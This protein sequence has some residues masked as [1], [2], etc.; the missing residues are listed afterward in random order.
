MMF[1]KIAFILFLSLIS[2]SALV[3]QEV[4]LGTLLKEMVAREQLAMFP[5]RDYTTEQFSSYDR[6][7]V[8]PDEENWFAN[9]D[10]TNFI[11][12][13][14]TENGD[15]WVMF[16]SQYPGAIVRWWMT[17]WGTGGEGIIRI[18]LDGAAKPVV[19]GTA[20]EVVSGGKIVGPPLSTSVSELTPYDKRG[21]N[22]YFPIPYGKSCKITYQNK[23]II[24]NEKG[25]IV[26]KSAA[27][28][29]IINYRKYN[30]ET[31]IESFTRN[32]ITSYARELS[33]AQLSLAMPFDKLLAT[34]PTESMKM[35]KLAS[36]ATMKLALS[37]AN[38]IKALSM[39]LE[40]EDLPQA[41]RSTILSVSFDQRETLK[42]PVGDF[43][44]TGYEINPYETYYTKVFNNGTLFSAWPMPF[45]TEAS[46][47]ITN[48]GEQE[49]K[50]QDLNVYLAPWQWD[51]RSMYFGG[52]WKQWYDKAT[53][54]GPT[55]EDL[56]FTTLEGKGV[57]VGD[58][59]TIYNNIAAWWGEGDEK[60]YVDGEDF[61]SHFGTGSEDYYGYA[62]SRPPVFSHPYIAQPDGS[63]NLDEGT[64]INIRF[65]GLDKIPFQESLKMT[66]ELWHHT[67][68]TVNYAPTTFFYLRPEGKTLTA[69][70]EQEAKRTVTLKT[71]V[72]SAK[73]KPVMKAGKIQGENLEAIRID[74][75]TLG[76]QRWEEPMWEEDAHLWWRQLEVGDELHLQFISD[77]AY[78]QENI[79]FQLTK[80]KD[81][82][83]A[84]ITL[85]DR[86]EITFD[87]YAP[88]VSVE[89]V[90]MKNANIKKGVNTLMIRIKG[91]ND[92]A[93][94]GY[95]F[96]I[97]YLSVK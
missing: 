22:L 47:S 19:E 18:Y 56:T 55:K 53:L 83:I 29:Y 2:A 16:D 60:I 40:A 80:A 11:R 4:T 13:E 24:T 63:G 54:S 71:E 64:A 75:G 70:D 69:F 82:G 91:K 12:R 62:W 39:Q 23:D 33:E 28:Y 3:A 31:R 21:H 7:S 84:T 1:N 5:E 37:G 15:E 34:P 65:R 26:D 48:L 32:S 45:Q 61:P 78:N 6:R 87:A 44:G 77:Q 17:F 85:N 36:G 66:M 95:Y 8:K 50:V 27:I 35:R 93:L 57:Y 46:I 67:Q 79:E 97:D 68:T 51:A 20:F 59:V 96:G 90:L 10:N 86:A 73:T 89:Q 81:Y 25:E 30:A 52:S 58:L 88:E 49:V 43:F 74:A 38:Y 92:Q 94:P 72:S 76:P 9:Q 41:L 42:I 14:V